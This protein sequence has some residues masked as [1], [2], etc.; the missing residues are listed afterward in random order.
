MRRR[1][2]IGTTRKKLFDFLA[3]TH[4]QKGGRSAHAPTLGRSTI[5]NSLFELLICSERASARESKEKESKEEKFSTP[6][7]WASRVSCRN[8]DC[9]HPV[10]R[11]IREDGVVSLANVEVEDGKLLLSDV[12]R[13]KF[14]SKHEQCPSCREHTAERKIITQPQIAIVDFNGEFHT[15][16][17]LSSIRSGFTVGSKSYMLVGAVMHV[18]VGG[19]GHWV[20]EVRFDK[21]KW[22][23]GDIYK[24]CRNQDQSQFFSTN[25]RPASV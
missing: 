17:K 19:A 24:R 14:E 3:A 10:G 18:S 25:S 20:F 22:H 15:K 5:I 11:S 6:F 1:G 2:V 21:N 4:I 12:F 9:P 16:V 7:R 23:F 8:P 13:Q